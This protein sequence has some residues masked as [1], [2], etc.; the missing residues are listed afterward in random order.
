MSR[1]FSIVCHETKQRL[2]I[3]Q[4]HCSP[5]PPHAPDMEVFYS[6]EF[7]TME[8]LGRFLR[9]TVGKTLVVL[10]EDDV[11]NEYTEQE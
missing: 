4:G 11:P 1:N 8:M 10:D 6:N 9:A 7:F 5:T 3:G 2:W